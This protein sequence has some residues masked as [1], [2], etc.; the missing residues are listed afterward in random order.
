MI[1]TLIWTFL[2]KTSA[3]VI[4]VSALMVLKCVFPEIT[5]AKKYEFE[6]IKPFTRLAMICIKNYISGSL[7]S[8]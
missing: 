6:S 2:R 7:Q 3:I 8:F 4:L 1:G 5:K